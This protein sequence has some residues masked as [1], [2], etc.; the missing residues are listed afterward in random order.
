MRQRGIS[1]YINYLDTQTEL[2]IDIKNNV[3]TCG[4]H[5]SDYK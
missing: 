5:K 2:D 4:C 1:K 3:L